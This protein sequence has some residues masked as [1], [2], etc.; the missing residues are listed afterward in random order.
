[1]ITIDTNIFVYLSDDDQPAK[2]AQARELI[3]ALAA[4]KVAVGLQVVGELQNVLRRKLRQ[5]P[6][7][8]AQAARNLIVR[9]ANFT[10]TP[11]A[12]E[13]AL[14]QLAAGRL[15]YWDALLLASANEAGCVQMLSEDLQDGADVL[16]VRVLNPFGPEGLNDQARA[17]IAS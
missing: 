6:W 14:T 17:L 8:A 11:S 15:N 5:P 4:D 7:I 12:V 16:G 10:A 1:M 3:A 13:L 2:Q 9:Y